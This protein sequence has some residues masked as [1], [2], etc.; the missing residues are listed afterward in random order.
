MPALLLMLTWPDGLTVQHL[1]EFSATSVQVRLVVVLERMN[2]GRA[3]ADVLATGATVSAARAT[4][5][6]TSGR[7]IHVHFARADLSPRSMAA[8]ATGRAHRH[9]RTVP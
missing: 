6:N 2:A 4:T 7:A 1:T 3:N 9:V 8:D 5:M